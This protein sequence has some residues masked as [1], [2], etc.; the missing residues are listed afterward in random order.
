ML[1]IE[2]EPNNSISA[3]CILALAAVGD[4][5]EASIGIVLITVVTFF[6]KLKNAI[7][8]EGDAVTIVEKAASF[9]AA[10]IVLNAIGDRILPAGHIASG[11]VSAHVGE[12]AGIGFAARFGT[13]SI[14][15]FTGGVIGVAISAFG[16]GAI[17]VALSRVA[18]VV[19]EF[20]SL[21]FTVA[22]DRRASHRGRI[23]VVFGE[24]VFGAPVSTDG[25]AVIAGFI[26]V[27]EAVTAVVILNRHR[28]EAD[29]E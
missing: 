8:T 3:D 6:A 1:G 5:I 18:A 21:N 12:H 27:N 26:T 17:S 13:I 14:A 4:V 28:G 11:G 20:G 15:N 9:G 10:A 19:T 22:T 7:A 24:A 2:V 16:R 29:A 25:I 23:E